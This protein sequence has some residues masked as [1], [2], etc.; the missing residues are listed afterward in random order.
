MRCQARGVLDSRLGLRVSAFVDGG[1]LATTPVPAISA[2]AAFGRPTW[3]KDFTP[4]TQGLGF[5]V[6]KTSE[7]RKLSSRTCA[8]CNGPL[9]VGSPHIHI[10]LNPKPI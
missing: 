4:S 8:T 7:N 10:P 2:S 3:C 6:P 5:S 9:R 1:I